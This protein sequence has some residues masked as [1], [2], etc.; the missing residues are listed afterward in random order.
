MGEFRDWLRKKEAE[1]LNE[2]VVSAIADTAKQFGYNKDY[3]HYTNN[4]SKKFEKVSIFD[5]DISKLEK[6]GKI[7]KKS[8]D[9]RL[10]YWI[11]DTENNFGEQSKA[12]YVSNIENTLIDKKRIVKKL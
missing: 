7:I 8:T 9:D 12:L 1:E 10:F 5:N 11:I 3:I 2:S 6:L 4:Q